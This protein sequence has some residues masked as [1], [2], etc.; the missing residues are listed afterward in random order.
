MSGW[1]TGGG[2]QRKRARQAGANGA[3][4]HGEFFLDFGTKALRNEIFVGLTLCQ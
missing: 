2:A 3:A 1:M 4:F